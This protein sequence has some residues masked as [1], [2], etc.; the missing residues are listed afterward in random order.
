[1]TPIAIMG[2][3]RVT[4]EDI[5]A[6]AVRGAGRKAD[7]HQSPVIPD[8]REAQIRDRRKNSALPAVPDL[9]LDFAEARP[10]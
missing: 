4:T 3:V 10:G 8:K 5:R 9:H 6:L 2:R 7:G 1:M